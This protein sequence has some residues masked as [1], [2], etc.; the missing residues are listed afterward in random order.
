MIDPNKRPTG[1]HERR[2]NARMGFKEVNV[3]LAD[4]PDVGS[5]PN[6]ERAI[7]VHVRNSKFDAIKNIHETH[8]SFDPLHFVLLYPRGEDGWNCEMHQSGSRD[9]LDR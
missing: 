2:Y 6:R 1:E 8:R 5:A 9:M 4:A 3:L 7:V